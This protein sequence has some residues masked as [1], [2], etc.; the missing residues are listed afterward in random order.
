MKTNHKI[1]KISALT[2]LLI[3]AG[4]FTTSCFLLLPLDKLISEDES[5]SRSE[6]VISKSDEETSSKPVTSVAPTEEISSDAKNSSETLSENDSSNSSSS[7]N[8]G[9][10]SE[11][12]IS[13]EVSDTPSDDEYI[14][15]TL[16][17][18]SLKSTYLNISFTAPSGYIMATDEEIDS[19]VTF[20]GEIIF[21]DQNKEI[22][23]YA[24]ANVV[25]EM[26]VQDSSG[27]PNMSIIV[28]KLQSGV[29]YDEYINSLKYQ[30]GN[31]D[32]MEYNF[33]AGTSEVMVAGSAYK[34]LS[35]QLVYMEIEMNQDFYMRIKG[36]RL[37]SITL[38]YSDDT[39][40]QANSL[41]NAIKTYQ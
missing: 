13:S 29:S 40:S 41:M 22:I 12:T 33:S 18:N 9:Q 39:R 38:T 21:K 32:D 34:K 23:D 30:M 5:E 16:T 36:D 14:K 15:G 6:I 20:T 35:A 1:L 2:V 17:S 7:E 31:I 24:K 25:Y 3:F 28:E 8:S 11:S 27:L 26:F 19:M 37:I 4:I 10:S